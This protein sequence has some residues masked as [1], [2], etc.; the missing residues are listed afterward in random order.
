M[1]I[2]C[3]PIGSAQKPTQKYGINN[4]GHQRCTS[5]PVSILW[6]NTWEKQHKRLPIPSP[7]SIHI[8]LLFSN[9]STF[10]N[11]SL[12]FSSAAQGHT[13]NSYWKEVPP[14][15][16]EHYV[17]LASKHYLCWQHPGRASKYSAQ[18]CFS[19]LLPLFTKTP[20]FTFLFMVCLVVIVAN[21]FQV[22]ALSNNS[23]KISVSGF[24]ILCQIYELRYNHLLSL[25]LISHQ[26]FWTLV[27]STKF[28]PT[29]P[30]WPTYTRLASSV[31]KYDIASLAHHVKWT[32]L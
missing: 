19:I 16:M 9:L 17:F 20:W 13:W 4:I 1:H 32:P 10:F 2:G 27:K 5:Q 23:L 8:L 29:F 3:E 31:L 21:V 26:M 28:S 14:L 24:Y 15:R 6:D 12:G 30:H 22:I 25:S 18:W 11:L 7:F